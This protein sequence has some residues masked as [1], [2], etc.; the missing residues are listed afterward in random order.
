M[1][2]GNLSKSGQKI[3]QLPLQVFKFR[4]ASKKGLKGKI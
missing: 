4:V 1:G 3:I 2:W